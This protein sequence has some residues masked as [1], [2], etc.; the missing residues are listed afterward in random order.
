M[1]PSCVCTSTCIH[2]CAVFK[3]VQ[4]SSTKFP[5]F[6]KEVHSQMHNLPKTSHRLML[7]LCQSRHVCQL[8]Y[9]L[10]NA[11]PGRRQGI[12]RFMTVYRPTLGCSTVFV[13][14]RSCRKCTNDVI[15]GPWSQE[16]PILVSLTQQ[17]GRDHSTVYCNT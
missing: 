15:G 14:R 7:R 9:Q 8:C 11:W 13:C 6:C 12:K 10:A 1:T 17:P 5:A 3:K 4:G 2:T 16:L